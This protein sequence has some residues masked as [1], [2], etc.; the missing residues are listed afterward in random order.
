MDLIRAE[1]VIS[2]YLF[3]LFILFSS[4]IL[5]HESMSKCACK[6]VPCS[7]LTACKGTRLATSENRCGCCFVCKELSGKRCVEDGDKDPGKC[8]RTLTCEN[9]NGLKNTGSCES[10]GMTFFH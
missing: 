1:F 9:K 6:N 4:S 10:V 3:L 8:E 2:E 7:S 5:S